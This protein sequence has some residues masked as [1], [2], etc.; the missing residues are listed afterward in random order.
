MEQLLWL[1]PSILVAFD[2]CIHIPKRRLHLWQT[3]GRRT[4]ELTEE[5][6]HNEA[7]KGCSSAWHQEFPHVQDAMALLVMQLLQ[8]LHIHPMAQEVPLCPQRFRG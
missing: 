2:V 3:L 7:L 1:T 6:I 4:I 5:L 8:T